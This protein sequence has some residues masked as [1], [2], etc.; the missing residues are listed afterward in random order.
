MPAL[1]RDSTKPACR[2]HPGRELEGLGLAAV[3]RQVAGLQA[4]RRQVQRHGAGL[5]AVGK[6]HAALVHSQLAQ[7]HA[8]CG[9]S[10]RSGWRCGGLRCG[11]AGGTG[12]GRGLEPAL[13]HP[14]AIG[15]A[16]HR[17]L[18][19]GDA[20][21]LDVHGARV[22]VQLQAVQRQLAHAGQRG[23]ALL[24]GQLL[25]RQGT[26]AERDARSACL[27]GVAS[28]GLPLQ[29]QLAAD[30]AGQ[31]GLQ[32]L[33]QVGRGQLQGEGLG[34]QAHLGGTVGG[35]TL[36]SQGAALHAQR[37]REGERGLEGIGH[38]G[39]I[40][41]EVGGLQ[42]GGGAGA[43]V[44]PAHLALAHGGLRHRHGPA[45]GGGCGCGWVCAAG[46]GLGGRCRR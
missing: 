39:H 27:G 28:R 37:A 18:G 40:Q 43:L 3:Q 41:R 9:C 26:R 45:G 22:Q 21:A 34:S 8:P 17:G 10:G 16:F 24:Q 12:G 46:G 5:G 2:G 31:H 6:G 11:G 19:L 15:G 33:G 14:A 13:G 36:E 25:Q 4:Q 29:G 20:Q 1:P 32:R 44:A 35:L 42:R 7:A 30:Q 23:L 38:I